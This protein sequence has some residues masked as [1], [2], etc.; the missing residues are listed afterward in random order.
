MPATPRLSFVIDAVVGRRGAPAV[1]GLVVACL[2]VYIAAFLAMRKV[3]NICFFIL[4]LLAVVHFSR[5]RPAF[6]AA[7]AVEGSRLFITALASLF[8]AVVAGSLLRGQFDATDFDGPSRYM[9]AGLLLLFLLDKRIRFVQVFEVAGPVALILALL[10]GLFNPE[11]A[12]RWGG[13][14]A[15]SFV[16]PNTLGS[17][18]V[19]LSFMTL[20]TLDAL[21][22]DALWL[23]VL[24]YAGIAAGLLLALLAASRGGWLAIVPLFALWFL[25][26]FRLGS[27]RLTHQALLVAAVLAIGL[28]LLPDVSDRALSAI[29]EVKGWFDG[30]Y[31][32]T[33]AEQRMGIWKLSLALFFERPFAG[34]GGA[35]LREQLARPEIA[36]LA[37]PVTANLLLYGGPHNDLL[38]MLLGS[39]ILGLAA[40]VLLL[41]A[42]M[43]FFWRRRAGAERDA[44]LACELGICYATGVFICGLSNEMLSLK[45]LASFYGLTMAG[46]AAQVLGACD[47][48]A[49]PSFRHFAE[50]T[51][52]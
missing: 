39:G 48:S 2:V 40:F 31:S 52:A 7:A 45:Y 50:S 10:A 33:D 6:K 17:Y 24:K 9:L 21:G 32:E 1:D 34:Y 5:H 20:L 12:S 49:T 3:T 38:G 35:G 18:A 11:V 26:R 22:K 27:H 36:M 37:S 23:R 13:R 47:R 4:L 29:D 43:A 19:I 25:F 46:L 14:F 42:P 8:V 15:T 44:R 28:L 30:T 16:D 51:R 41:F